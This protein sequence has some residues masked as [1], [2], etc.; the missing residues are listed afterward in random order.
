MVGTLEG[1]DVEDAKV[2]HANEGGHE[3]SGSN[4]EGPIF[5]L[6]NLSDP[7]PQLPKNHLW[8]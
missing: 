4:E 1:L 5:F 8:I 2:L 6:R 7:Q 3:D